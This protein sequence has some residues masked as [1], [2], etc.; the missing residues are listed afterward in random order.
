[1]TTPVGSGSIGGVGD[2]TFS[3]VIWQAPNI[4]VGRRPLRGSVAAHG[5]LL[6]KER[7]F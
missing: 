1:V 5:A 7:R 4:T 3:P 6:R 2:I